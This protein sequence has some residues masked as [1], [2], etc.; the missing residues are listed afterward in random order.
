MSK[1]TQISR[2]AALFQALLPTLLPLIFVV[3][4][5]GITVVTA[6]RAATYL[7]TTATVEKV[8]GADDA[9]DTVT[10]HY[11]YSVNGK[12]YTSKES[13]DEDHKSEFNELR[14]HKLGDKLTVYYSP[15]N[16]SHSQQVVKPTAFGLALVIFVVPFLAIGFNGLWFAFTGKELLLSRRPNAESSSVPGGGLFWVLVLVC[17]A[18]T[19][20]QVVASITLTWPWDLVAGLVTLFVA[21]PAAMICAVRLRENRR[22]V[23]SEELRAI[24]AAKQA[25]PAASDV[26]DSLDFARSSPRNLSFRAEFA[27]LLAFA[28]IWCGIVGAFTYFAIGSL[29]KHHYAK[30]Y[31]AQTQGVVLASRIK[32]SHGDK[33]DTM[34][35]RIKYRYSVDGKQ[36][37]GDRY[38]FA[39]GS[40]SDGSYAHKAVQENPLGKQV[41]VYYDPANPA[42]AILRLDTPPISYTLLLFLQ[43]FLLAGLALIGLCIQMPFVRFRT[44]RFLQSDASPPWKIPGWGVMRDSFEGLVI[45]SRPSLFAPI[46]YFLVAYGLT[47]FIAI[48]IVVIFFNGFGNADLDAIRWAFIVAASVGAVAFF[49]GLFYRGSKRRVVI[50]MAQKRLAVHER[51]QD[52]DVPFADI[53]GLQLHKVNY[54][55]GL[56][57]NG[58]RVHYLRLEALVHAGEPIT[59][60][61]FKWQS[62]NDAGLLAVARKTKHELAQMIGC[63]VVSEILT[64]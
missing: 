40:S 12:H 21:I 6:Y 52:V 41:P 19:V 49:V 13:A 1:P 60:H 39:G 9:S 5:V 47:C 3:V 24:R 10:V 38:D 33:G 36:Y 34:A 4:G 45:Q 32:V 7:P 31:F 56:T 46:G 14:R 35:P 28:T 26:A 62:G 53:N 17:V 43:P 37:I 48:F 59:I 23:R 2:I 11:S 18:G 8:T 58:S 64:G 27:I 42:S 25:A 22:L 54:R 44:K 16:P 61:S 15:D 29:I 55:A 50:D 51:R 57:V 30:L 63:P 20:A